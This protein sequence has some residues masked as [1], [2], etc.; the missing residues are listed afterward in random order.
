MRSLPPAVAIALA[1]TCLTIQSVPAAEPPAELTAEQDHRLMMETLG[2][3]SLRPGANPGDPNAPNQPNA[4]ESK[5]SPYESLPDPLVMDDG[6]PVTTAEQWRD[7]RRA[8]IVEL[9]EREIYGRVPDDAPAV[10]WEVT[11]ATNGDIAGVAATT[12]KLLGRVDNSAYPELSVE[13]DATL[14][15][16]ADANGPAPVIVE[17]GWDP[18]M[19]RRRG[20]DENAGPPPT[21]E[22]QKLLLEAGWGYAILIPTS[23]QADNGAGLTK[24]VIGLTNKGQPREPEDWGALR[25]WAW[26]ASRL[27]DYFETDDA[28]DASRVGI[29]GLSRYGKAAAVAMAF[30]ERFAIGFIGSSGQGGVKIMR[31][32]YGERVENLA[33][34]GGY[35]WMAGNYLKY[36]GPMTPNDLPVDA[37]ELVAL[38]APR[39]VFISVGS[40]NVEGKWIDSRGTFGATAEASPV[41]ELLGKRGLGTTEMPEEGVGL[42]EGDLAFRQHHGGHTTGPNWPDFIAFAKRHL[43]ADEA[44]E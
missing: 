38:M 1:A 19:F 33:G 22:W 3:E 31:R 24:G 12:K 15:T 4:D 35:H 9:F 26:G 18:S 14:V 23:F 28:V 39:P 41:Y 7:D 32:D 37:H 20:A 27:L 25:A 30:D 8:E 21:P 40:E 10:E 5:A 42:L 36:A 2:I 6:T 29:E 11:S 16:P 43:A 17:F 44:G 13:I 34:S